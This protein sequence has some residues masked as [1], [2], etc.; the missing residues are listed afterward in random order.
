MPE[1]LS[2]LPPDA[3]SLLEQVKAQPEDDAPRLVLADWLQEC[4]P[5][6]LAARGEFI[7]LQVTRSRLAPDDPQQ[8][9]L[10]RLE[11]QLLKVHVLDWLG[12]LADHFS[13]WRFERGLI[14]LEGR[15]ERVLRRGVEE[16]LPL[17]CTIWVEALQL[18]EMKPTHAADLARFPLLGQLTSLDL[19]H[20]RLGWASFARLMSSP[21]L[22]RLVS[23]RLEGCRIQAHGAG[24]LARS[25]YLRQLRSLDLTDNRIGDL[26]AT[27]LACSHQ[28]P[29]LT[30]IY[31]GGNGIGVEGWEK[32]QARFPREALFPVKDQENRG[33]QQPPRR[34]QVDQA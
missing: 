31:L 15:A 18:A 19:S 27:D 4:C 26:G 8:A 21:H 17:P 32:L 10:L 22:A 14:H 23:L 24:V 6:S 28:L 13:G 11:R 12:P 25:P 1:T 9:V 30:R 7:H 2:D 20:N 5:P 16:T 34:R 29:A 33:G 3:V